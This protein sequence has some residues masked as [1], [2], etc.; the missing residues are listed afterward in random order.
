MVT[1]DT[2][3]ITKAINQCGQ[4][5]RNP[6]YGNIPTIRRCGPNLWF[7]AAARDVLNDPDHISIDYD[8]KTGV[9]IISPSADA[10]EFKV[11]KANYSRSFCCTRMVDILRIQ[12]HELRLMKQDGNQLVLDVHAEECR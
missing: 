9:V 8:E 4:R 7:N 1:G 12:T 2:M 11:T 5:T 6:Y 10:T 3:K